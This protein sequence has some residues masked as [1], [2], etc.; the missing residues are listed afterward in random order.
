M[1]LTIHYSF[2]SFAEGP[3]QVRELVAKLRDRAL[4]LP[5]ARV[6]EI[7]ERKGAECDFEQ[8]ERE[9]PDRWLLIQAG[10]S[11]DRGQHSY[12]VNPNHL[13]AFSTWPGEGCEEANFGLCR[14]PLTITVRE[15][16]RPDRFRT[17]RT[18]LDG[19]RWISFCKTQY[20]SNPE[21]GG[22]ENFLRCH[23]SV[24]SLLDQARELGILAEVSDEGEFWRKRDVRALAQ[25][26]GSWNEMIASWAGQLKDRFGPNIVAEINK[27][28]NFEHLEAKGRGGSFGS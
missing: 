2:K 19:W 16:E 8:C 17:L 6:G 22:V 27:F 5:L 3:A 23:L 9:Y 28:P 10:Q 24:I 18:R 15:P 14:Y 25:E 12:S 21:C 13:I 11:V 20:A 4:E 26:V 1:G 7:I